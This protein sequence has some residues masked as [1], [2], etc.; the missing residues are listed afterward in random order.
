ML[1]YELVTAH[2]ANER[3][4]LRITRRSV[5]IATLVVLSAFIALSTA[6]ATNT[7]TTPLTDLTPH[8]HFILSHLNDDVIKISD[9]PP[10]AKVLVLG[11]DGVVGR[12]MVKVR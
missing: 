6:T 8:P 10:G 11:S 4:C 2:L 9:I 3:N 12:A 5:I 1:A 7:T